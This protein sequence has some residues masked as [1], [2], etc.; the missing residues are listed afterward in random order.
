[1]N[2]NL[3]CII[4]ALVLA[5]ILA[6]TTYSTFFIVIPMKNLAPTLG[7]KIGEGFGLVVGNAVGDAEGSDA[8]KQQ[9]AIDGAA[10]G[11]SAE[12]T[13]TV[14]VQSALAE[15]GRL[16]V[17]SASVSLR[18]F[19]QAGGGKYES[20]EVV[21]GDATFFVDLN[22]A[23]ISETEEGEILI[24]IPNPRMELYIDESKSEL[25]AEREEFS[26]SDNAEAGYNAYIDSR[27][28]VFEDAKGK[29]AHF[30]WL[31]SQARESAKN[32]IKSIVKNASIEEKTVVVVFPGKAGV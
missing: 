6:F 25:L 28:E 22:D 23:V 11:S 5:L 15:V 19:H 10:D 13:T 1:M 8:G 4:V 9:G 30:D 21:F 7:A 26:W 14:R 32:S 27:G 2:K 20:L 16:D 12:Y 3:V 31:L 29:M 24:K 18:N 17:L